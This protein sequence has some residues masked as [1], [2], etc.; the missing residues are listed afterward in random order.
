MFTLTHKIE[1]L[2]LIMI[3]AGI[4]LFFAININKPKL[5]IAPSMIAMKVNPTATPFPTEMFV[6]KESTVSEISSDATRK[7]ILKTIKNKDKTKTVTLST[8]DEKENSEQIIFI[9]TIGEDVSIILP[10]NTWSPDNKYFFIQEKTSVSNEIMVFKAKG[11]PF[12]SGDTYLDLTGLFR[13]KATGNNFSEATGWASET[14]IIVNT[15]TQDSVKGP[16]YWF[17]V[18]SKAII[19][20]STVF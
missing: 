15:T 16:S 4:G 12:D 3:A 1:G 9:K 13:D 17:E 8:Q 5:N 7:V 2:L 20:L 11:E 18:P 19:Q 10:Y 6:P 14:L